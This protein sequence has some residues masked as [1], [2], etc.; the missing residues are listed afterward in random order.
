MENNQV[1]CGDY[2]IL[3]S[4][5]ADDDEQHFNQRW[6]FADIEVFGISLNL[7]YNLQM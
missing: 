2:S 5:R 3:L 1:K 7:K 4:L 6:P